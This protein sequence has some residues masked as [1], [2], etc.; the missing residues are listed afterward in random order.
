MVLLLVDEPNKPPVD[1]VL[2]GAPKA[3]VVAPKG[4]FWFCVAPK[5]ELVA[6]K[7]EPVL[8]LPKALPVL[9][10]EPKP[11]PVFRPNALPLFCPKV[12]VLLP[13]VRLEGWPN[14]DLFAVLPNGEFELAPKVLPPV[15]PNADP[16]LVAPKPLVDP[17]NP[18]TTGVLPNRRLSS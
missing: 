3:L 8:V 10:E 6:P 14:A 12:D 5:A 7:P 11:P 15:A 16:V 1:V 18:S 2:E 13:K 17:P 4:W 9:V